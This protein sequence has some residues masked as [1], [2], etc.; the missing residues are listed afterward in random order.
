MQEV[1]NM[2]A[3]NLIARFESKLDAQNSRAQD[4]TLKMLIWMIAAAGAI[5]GILIRLWG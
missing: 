5:I 3:A 2:A 4:S 1:G